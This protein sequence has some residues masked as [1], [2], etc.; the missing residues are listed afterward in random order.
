MS[1]GRYR[2]AVPGRALAEDQVGV[3]ASIAI[4]KA[5][6]SRRGR[7]RVA[8]TITSLGDEVKALGGLVTRDLDPPRRAPSLDDVS[9][10]SPKQ[11]SGA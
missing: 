10:R 7:R 3:A 2:S 9:S 11:L 6:L 8:T 4:L 5:E 1:I